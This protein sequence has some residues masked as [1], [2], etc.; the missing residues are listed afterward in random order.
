[1]EVYTY[2]FPK[3]EKLATHQT[4]AFYI[5]F[6]FIYFFFSFF[7]KVLLRHFAEKQ[8]PFLLPS[9]FATKLPYAFQNYMASMIL[10]QKASLKTA[11]LCVQRT[12]L[13]SFCSISQ[14]SKAVI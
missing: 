1:M 7:I 14:L 11:N 12:P 6:N 13:S 5:M 10:N 4:T 3:K 2:S 9:L 8:Q